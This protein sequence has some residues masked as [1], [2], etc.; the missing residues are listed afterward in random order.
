MSSAPL[1]ELTL[2]DIRSLLWLVSQSASP[3]PVFVAVSRIVDE[4]CGYRLLTVLQYDEPAGDVVRRFSTDPQYPVGGRKALAQYPTNHA[5]I[6][7]KGFF[8]AGTR[9]AVRQAYADYEQLLAMGITAILNAPIRYAGRRLGTLNISG[10]EG[11]YGLRE[12]A[13]ARMLSGLLVPCLLD[14]G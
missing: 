13:V 5:A 9:D 3:E 4:T 1:R 14:P 11:Q 8:L 6:E 10:G 7:A 12:V 2:A